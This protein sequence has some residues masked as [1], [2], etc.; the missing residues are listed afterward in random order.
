MDGISRGGRF[1][2]KH[3]KMMLVV[4]G[5]VV[6]AF[7]EGS[8]PPVQKMTKKKMCTRSHISDPFL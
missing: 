6:G 4:K 8:E 7:G 5:L 1:D 3:S 2:Q